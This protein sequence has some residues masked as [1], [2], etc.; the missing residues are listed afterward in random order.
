MRYALYAIAVFLTYSAIRTIL[1][2]G[3]PRKG[4]T[5]AVAAGAVVI[6]AAMITIMILAAGRLS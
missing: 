6:Q 3:K 4:I 5:P 2:I 1:D